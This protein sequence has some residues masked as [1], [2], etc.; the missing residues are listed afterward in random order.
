MKIAKFVYEGNIRW[1]V[2]SGNNVHQI[3]GTLY[4]MT[5]VGSRIC[6]ASN[7][8]YLAPVLATSKVP[9]IAANYGDK[10]DRDG[11]GIF[12]KQPGTYQ[13][14]RKGIVFPR[15]CKT[16]IHEAELGIV[17]SKKGRHI[18]EQDALDH[19][20]G[21]TC[22]NDVSAKEMITSD[23]GKGTSMRWKH[24]DTFCPIGPF[25]ETEV[26]DPNNLNIECL[27]NGKI[28]ASGNTSD[29][30]FPVSKLISWVSEVMTLNPGDIIP[31][32]CPETA[33]IV[34]GD[35]VEVK[36]ED[37]GSLINTVVKDY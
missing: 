19:V 35:V 29:M 21:Y 28:S 17:I 12:M 37:V 6:S 2:L 9:A 3:K 23:Q 33:E 14:H 1:G 34:V 13:A 15:S 5:G 8:E 11:P 24:F 20:L 16:I 22:V 32:G 10:D 26:S 4:N 36:I 25:I 27:V 30:I 7:I 31:T 18:E